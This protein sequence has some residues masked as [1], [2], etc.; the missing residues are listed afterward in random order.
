VGKHILKVT[1]HSGIALWIGEVKMPEHKLQCYIKSIKSDTSDIIE[2]S[3]PVILY[4]TMI[5]VVC[6]IMMAVAWFLFVGIDQFVVMIAPFITMIKPFFTQYNTYMISMILVDILILS[7][8]YISMK[9]FDEDIKSVSVQIVVSLI[10]LVTLYV[11]NGILLYSSPY[12]I[13]P[14]LFNGWSYITVESVIN[15]VII[16]IGV[17]LVRAY[18]RC[19]KKEE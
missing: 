3:K 8:V 17:F 12:S 18:V 13:R 9:S 5:F 7:L 14:E 4:F 2:S 1:H 10:S 16:T 19:E 6:L 15:F 11:V